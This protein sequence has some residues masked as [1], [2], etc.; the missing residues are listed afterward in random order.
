[1]SIVKRVCGRTTHR[2]DRLGLV[3][4]RTDRTLGTQHVQ[5]RMAPMPRHDRQLSLALRPPP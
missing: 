2:M 4:K 1:M 5:R 3:K